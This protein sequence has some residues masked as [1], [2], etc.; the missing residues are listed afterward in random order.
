MPDRQTFDAVTTPACAVTDSPI[1]MDPAGTDA[2]PASPAPYIPPDA[3]EAYNAWGATC[4]PAALAAILARPVMSLRE[5]MQPY[6][7]YT[8][9]ADMRRALDRLGVSY[10]VLRKDFVV[11]GGSINPRCPSFVG[12]L[13]I[14]QFHGSWMNAGVHPGAALTRTHWVAV[15]HDEES[16]YD[17]NA[18]PTGDGGWMSFADW[19]HIIVPMIGDTKR[20]W[21]GKWSV[22]STILVRRSNA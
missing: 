2:A 1:A 15:N 6:K 18:G 10:R 9:I 17:V 19:D 21:D 22:R 12:R 8:P 20:G 14:I 11:Q 7:G 5:A 13:S 4:G 3:E 16:I